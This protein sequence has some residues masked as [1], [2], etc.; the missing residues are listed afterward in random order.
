M[1]I[2]LQEAWSGGE[3]QLSH[4]G[5]RLNVRIPP[6]ARSEQRIPIIGGGEPGKNGG[7]PGDLYIII[8]VLPDEQFRRDGDDLYL[9][10]DLEIDLNTALNGGKVEILIFSGKEILNVPPGIPNLKKACH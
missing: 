2:S 4:R 6:G 7:P 9:K 3:H 5:A 8:E 10:D 1:R